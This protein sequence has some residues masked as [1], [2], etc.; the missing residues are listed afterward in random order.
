MPQGIP[1]SES[2]GERHQQRRVQVISFCLEFRLVSTAGSLYPTGGPGSPPA[3]PSAHPTR[4]GKLRGLIVVRIILSI[5]CT[6]HHII[7]HLWKNLII[8]IYD[9]YGKVIDFII[10][11]F[12]D[13][14]S[15]GA[16]ITI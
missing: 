9:F 16:I 11:Y 2:R 1:A 3:D 10:A 12:I 8:F 4:G 7:T 6:N 13:I 14:I 5:T 15:I